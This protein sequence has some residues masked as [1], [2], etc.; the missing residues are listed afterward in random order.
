MDEPEVRIIR[1]EPMHVASF[2]AYGASPEKDTAAKL[3]AWAKPKGYL[4]NPGKHRIF[5]FDNPLPSVGTPNYGYEMWI[6]VEPGTEAG[7]GV[8]IK[9]VDGGLYAVT[10][11]EVK[12]NPDTFIPTVWMKLWEWVEKNN[13]YKYEMRQSLEEHLSPVP[14]E[15]TDYFTLDLYLAVEG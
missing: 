4:D 12:G 3:V 13:E 11:C 1:L 7:E 15:V 6:Q 8:E 14:F 10:R 2:Q 9:D 5:G